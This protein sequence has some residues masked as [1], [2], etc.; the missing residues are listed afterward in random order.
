MVASLK[1]QGA[2]EVLALP[3]NYVYRWIHQIL[4]FFDL[5][6]KHSHFELFEPLNRIYNQHLS[7]YDYREPCYRYL[8]AVATSSEIDITRLAS[9]LQS[10][11]GSPALIAEADNLLL[12]SFRAV[13]AR[14]ADQL[15]STSREFETLEQHNQW[16]AQEIDHLRSV[17]RALEEHNQWAKAEIEHLH[18]V[19]ARLQQDNQW[20]AQEIQHLRSSLSRSES[21]EQESAEEN[22][23]SAP[24][25]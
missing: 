24:A 9:R 8:M 13:D 11:Q 2:D 19:I 16:A 22:L 10:P 12:E 15:R 4:I 18:S 20:A 6:Y 21:H 25:E 14:L 1:A 23:P 17:N 3:C 7:G 5:Q